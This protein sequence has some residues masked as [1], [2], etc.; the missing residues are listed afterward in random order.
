[1]V[2][3]FRTC[4]SPSLVEASVDSSELSGFSPLLSSSVVVVLQ[5]AN[6]TVADSTIR[7]ASISARNFFM[8]FSLNC[9]VKFDL[10]SKRP[11]QYTT[12]S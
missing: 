9:V 7:A 1:M 10:S 5:E 11:K 4:F 12:L 8:F 6:T 2:A 3:I